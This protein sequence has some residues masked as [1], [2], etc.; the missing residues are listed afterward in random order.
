MSGMQAQDL[1]YELPQER[2]AR[3]PSERR[4]ESRLLVF[5]RHT[6]IVQHA[7]FKDLPNFL[8]ANFNLFRNDAA[9]LKARIFAR[10]DSGAAVECLLLTPENGSNV[11]SC[12]LKPGKRLQV[13]ACFGLEGEFTARVLSKSENGLALVEFETTKDESVIELSERIGVVP[14]PPYIARDQRAENYDKSFDN[15]RYQTVYANSAKPVAAAAPTAGL[16]FTKELEAQLCAR[17]NAFYNLT[18]NVGIGTFQ[19][20]KEDV[21]EKHEMH[22]EIYEIP[23]NTLSAMFDKSRP[24]LAVGTTSL[25]AMEDFCRKHIEK[26]IDIGKSYVGAAKLFVYPPQKIISADAM[27]TNFHLP[28]S[29]LMCLVATFIS[30]NNLNG[31]DI[32]KNLYAEAIAREYN[33]FSYGDAMLII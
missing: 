18:L 33:F 27:I 26:N 20:V 15:E 32:L 4:D 25:R 16:H 28:R 30:P 10:K 31:I 22:S 24:R 1:D 9:V 11:W 6:Q 8:P 19:P 23:A 7:R 21:V 17:G 5:D 13:G 14:L 3:F 29:T 2:I 12:M